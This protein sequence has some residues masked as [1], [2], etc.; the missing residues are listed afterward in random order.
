MLTLSPVSYDQY[1]VLQQTCFHLQNFNE[2][3]MIEKFIE[4]SFD[5]LDHCLLNKQSRD[6]AGCATDVFRTMD[7]I[8]DDKI[9]YLER[10][11]HRS[12]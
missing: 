8:E 9:A 11:S 6:P 5:D 7:E 4:V 1:Q 2:F 12:I 10:Q 3:L